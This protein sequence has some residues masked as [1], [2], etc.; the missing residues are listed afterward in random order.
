MAKTMDALLWEKGWR[1]SLRDI[2]H[3]F[4]HFGNSN[5]DF[6]EGSNIFLGLTRELLRG[7]KP[8]MFFATCL[9]ITKAHL[10]QKF[11]KAR[12]KWENKEL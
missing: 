9:N 6:A 8:E 11:K 10:E 7:G 1:R 3:P 12:D 2:V 4:A 5:S